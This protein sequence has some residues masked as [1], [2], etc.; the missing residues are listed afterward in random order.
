MIG[1]IECCKC[2]V[3]IG[4]TIMGVPLQVFKRSNLPWR[5]AGQTPNLQ[6]LALI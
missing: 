2:G 3:A 5:V 6:D 1:L 4:G